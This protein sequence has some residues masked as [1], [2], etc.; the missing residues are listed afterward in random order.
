MKR[1]EALAP[2]SHAAPPV[3]RRDASSSPMPNLCICAA[4]HSGTNAQL[5]DWVRM[6]RC[7]GAVRIALQDERVLTPE[8]A[9]VAAWAMKHHMQAGVLTMLDTPAASRA[10]PE[11]NSTPRWVQLVESERGDASPGELWRLLLVDGS[12]GGTV[13]QP[14]DRALQDE[15]RQVFPAES[16]SVVAHLEAPYEYLAAE[17]AGASLTAP[18]NAAPESRWVPTSTC[19]TT[20][21]PPTATLQVAIARAL[22]ELSSITSHQEHLLS[23]LTFVRP[24]RSVA[25]RASQL[26][27]WPPRPLLVRATWRNA[28]WLRCRAVDLAH[29]ACI[30]EEDVAA[31]QIVQAVTNSEAPPLLHPLIM[32]SQQS[33]SAQRRGADGTEAEGKRAR[34]RVHRATAVQ[35]S[36]GENGLV[37]DPAWRMELASC[38]AVLQ[39]FS[40]PPIPTPL[41]P[42]PQQ[43][44]SPPSQSSRAPPQSASAASNGDEEAGWSAWLETAA[45]VLTEGDGF[46]LLRQAWAAED[47]RAL[48]AALLT[49][50]PPEKQTTRVFANH[51]CQIHYDVA[52]SPGRDARCEP[53]SPL[54]MQL[55]LHPRILQLAAHLLGEGVVLHNAGLSLVSHHPH[56]TDT[57][58][59]AQYV[60]HADQPINRA[61]VWG[62]RV[63]PAS[64]PLSLQALWLLDDFD[65]DSGAT[66]VLP[67]TQTRWEH[68]DAWNRNRSVDH[69]DP[70]RE[71]AGATLSGGLFPHRFVSGVAGDVVLALG[72]LWHAPSTRT[73]PGPRLALLFEYAPSF[74]APR[75][76]YSA[77]LVHRHVKD[78]TVRRIFPLQETVAMAAGRPLEDGDATC[79]DVDHVVSVYDW[80]ERM[81]SSPQCVTRHTRVALRAGGPAIP[82]FG[83]GTGSPEDNPRILAAS[84]RAGVRLVVRFRAPAHIM[85]RPQSPASVLV[86]TACL[87]DSLSHGMRPLSLVDPSQLTRAIASVASL[88]VTLIHAPTCEPRYHSDPLCDDRRHRIRRSCTA[89]SILWHRRSNPQGCTVRR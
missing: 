54:L 66:Y 16:C 56:T 60:P 83:L 20:P 42:A 1:R 35:S 70:K 33:P 39:P 50:L 75:D 23:V 28:S 2:P 57:V 78:P 58:S 47:A 74:V 45:S 77:A 52:Q 53:L 31:L 68:V 37:E 21:R 81:R 63:P 46:T 17:D 26:S 87:R 61:E 84:L 18:E 71:A 73:L 86:A 27:E 36:G 51:M 72:S 4:M 79:R 19:P 48:R 49:S 13:R 44:A 11:R 7:T 76:R 43:P 89:M 40:H 34:L 65:Y 41:P 55:P 29:A 38:D 32:G 9:S 80:P 88:A 6:Q 24:P 3:Q 15:C 69:L 14:P 67:R 30:A 62:G 25:A 5:D 10:H 12:R 59:P 64:H 22:N 8:A 85:T 82:V